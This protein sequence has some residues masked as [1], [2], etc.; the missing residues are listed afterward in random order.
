MEVLNGAFTEE[1][2]SQ[3]RGGNPLQVAQNNAN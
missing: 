1:H 3:P 2:F